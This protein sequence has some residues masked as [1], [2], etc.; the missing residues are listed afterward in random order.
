M[1][2]KRKIELLAPAR[3]AGIAVDAIMHGA[4]AVY[5]GAPAFGARAAAGNSV[6]D[7]ARVADIAHRYRAKVYA[8]VNTIIYDDELLEAERMI[9]SLY[10]AG[11]DAIIVQDMGILRLDIPPIELH[12]STQCDIRSPQKARWLESLGFSQIVLARE[13]TSEEIG[14]ICSAVSVAVEC[15]VHGALCVS[16]SGRCQIS[17]VLRGRSANRGECAQMC[18]LPYD[19]VDAAGNVLVAN[20]HLL[21]L[22]DLNQSDRLESLLPAGVS[23]LKIEGRLKDASYVRNV[24]AHYRRRVD[25]IIAA[26]PDK[27]ERASAGTSE[28]GFTPD[29]LKSFNRSFTHYF[30]DKRR[31]DDGQSMASTG[32]PKSLGEP[33]GVVAESRNGRVRV[34]T[35]L[36]LANG[37]GFSYFSPSGEYRGFKA[38]RVDGDEVTPLGEVRLRP[39]TRLYRTY[40]SAFEGELRHSSATRYIKVEARLAYNNGVLSL[41]MT[42]ERG[43]GVVCASA[44]AL[45]E[46]RSPQGATQRAILS[47]LGGTIYRLTAAEVVDGLFIPSSLLASLRRDAVARLDS[48]ARMRYRRPLRLPE[49]YSAPCYNTTLDCA[50]N[51]ANSLAE[52]LYRQHGATIVERAIEAGTAAD[53]SRAVMHTRYCLRRELDACLKGSR[54]GRLPDRLYL[55]YGK[56]LRLRLEFD[57]RNCEMRVYSV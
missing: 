38:N 45:D 44:T 47:R 2:S 48:A 7:I 57:C 34:N 18:R 42:D 26:N 9:R 27:Y 19:L 49:D 55:R 3:D 17:Q 1:Q 54:S 30:Y 11:T 10:H 43:V 52:T 13:L 16:Y 4:D 51:V 53:G 23:S 29:P 41:G 25:N 8:T 33:C 15:F 5:I 36:S 46:A 50:D 31:P 32:T 24:V 6:D 56:D 20:K 14:E 37:D 40:D 21:S 39:G 12:A 28:V 22:R 35:G